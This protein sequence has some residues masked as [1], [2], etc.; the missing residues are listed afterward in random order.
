MQIPNNQVPENKLSKNLLIAAPSLRDGCFDRSVIY[1]LEHAQKQSSI[2]LILNHPTG[3]SVGQ[4]IASDTFSKLA[5]LPVS[6]GGPVESDQ[7][8]F[9]VFEWS[10]NSLICSTRISAEQAIEAM[11]KRENLVRAFAG[12]S[13]WTPGQLH[14]ELKNQAWITAYS[15][16]ASLNNSLVEDFW[17]ESLR[18]ISPFHHILSLTPANPTLN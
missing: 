18:E 17:A 16:K 2:G 10:N 8:H 4:L 11:R 15:S 7:L 12:H 13:E 1:M 5:H 3:K 14:E 9:A 6:Y